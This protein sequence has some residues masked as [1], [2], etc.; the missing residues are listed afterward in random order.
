MDAKDSNKHSRRF[1]DPSQRHSETTW[2]AC[3]PLSPPVL[4]S[5]LSMTAVSQPEHSVR[6]VREPMSAA[7]GKSAASS[8]ISAWTAI[9]LSVAPP[10]P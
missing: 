3:S 1:Q 2:N 5:T 7:M 4:S 8:A 9:R 6:I 10:I